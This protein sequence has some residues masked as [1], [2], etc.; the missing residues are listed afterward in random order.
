[1]KRLQSEVDK[2]LRLEL[3]GHMLTDHTWD[4]FEHSHAF[5]EL[6]YVFKGPIVLLHDSQQQ[7]IDQGQWLIVP[8]DLS[9]C[10]TS[11]SPSSFMY[12]GFKTNLADL[13]C[14]CLRPFQH[15]RTTAFAVLFSQLNDMVD[16]V[17]TQGVAFDTFTPRLL[18]LMISA[19]SSLQTNESIADPKRVLSNKIKQYIHHN[20]TK[21]IRVDEIAAGLYHTPHY[22]GNV[23]ASVNGCTIKEYALQYKMNQAIV[24]LQNPSNSIADVAGMVGFESPHY[25]SKC[26]KTY[27]GF[28]PS[29]L[30]NKENLS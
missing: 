27:F 16:M 21:P 8:S 26:F 1:M 5:Y 13:S 19:I 30:K 4:G 9:H 11:S 22:L 23:F 3:V 2:Y 20:Y 10:I 7:I 14:E 28:S 17:F 29:S 24:M 15:D 18:S 12:I 25:F 6:I